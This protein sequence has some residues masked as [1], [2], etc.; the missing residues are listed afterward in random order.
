MIRVKFKMADGD[1]DL[2]VRGH[3]P[4]IVCAMVSGM[5][6]ACLYGLQCMAD[7]YP[8]YVQCEGEI[9]VVTPV[10]LD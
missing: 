5:V 6:Q 1:V 4:R 3:G 7:N 8:K 2:T 10:P 9:G